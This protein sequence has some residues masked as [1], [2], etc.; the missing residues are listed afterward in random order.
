MYATITKD[1]GIHFFSH[2]A[3]SVSLHTLTATI[4]CIWSRTNSKLCGQNWG[5]HS[6]SPR[7]GECSK[8]CEIKLNQRCK[9][10]FLQK[11]MYEF[12][13]FETACLFSRSQINCFKMISLN[14][15][16][17]YVKSLGLPLFQILSWL[18]SHI[19]MMIQAGT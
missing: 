13:Q 1:S 19:P 6:Q 16:R 7:N 8:V 9:V 15:F 3:V 5:R 2:S 17:V 10:Y 11:E 4:R 12:I 18:L 14:F